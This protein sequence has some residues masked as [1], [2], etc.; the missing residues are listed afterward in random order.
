MGADLAGDAL[1]GGTDGGA[2]PGAD[3]IEPG[4]SLGAADDRHRI[5]RDPDPKSRVGYVRIIGL[6]PGAGF[7]LTVI[8]DPEDWSGV[9]AWKTGGAPV[10]SG[11]HARRV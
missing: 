4:W 3:D 1:G 9:T 6:S 11:G 2:E 5:V 7:V 10:T 8:A